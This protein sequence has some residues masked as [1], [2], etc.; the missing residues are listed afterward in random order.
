MSETLLLPQPRAFGRY[1]VRRL[2]NSGG[3]GDVYEAH[4]PLID[5]TVAVKMIRTGSLSGTQQQDYLQR[6]RIEAQAG[7]RC[8]HPSIVAIFDAGEAEGRPYLVMEFVNGTSLRDAADTPEQRE[9]LDP[10][11]IIA[12]V[13][14]ALGH[15]H[16]LGIIHRDIK[17]ANIM[18]TQNGAAKVADFGIARIDQGQFTLSGDILGTPS[19]MA[20]EQANGGTVDHRA[21]LFSTAAVLHMLVSGRP[22][23]AGAN[24]AETL[25]RLTAPD[26]ADLTPLRGSRFA[27]LAPV[28]ARGL[29]KDK[30]ARFASAAEFAAALRSAGKGAGLPAAPAI[31]APVIAAA[32]AELARHLGPIAQLTAAEAARKADGEEAFHA[33]IARAMPDAKAAQAYLSRNTPPAPA[34]PQISGAMIDAATAILRVHIG[35]I[36]R[37]LTAEAARGADNVAAFIEAVANSVPGDAEHIRHKLAAALAEAR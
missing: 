20:P 5:R 7:G 19:Y 25:R 3:V 29:A 37:L 21:D 27:S 31:P 36:A 8:V 15:A 18:L 13:L 10:Q 26:P 35:P 24:M 17:P 6:F 1:L 32:A 22:P 16:G 12:D 33:L 9:A 30:E 2:I 14:A 34:M 23:F 11:A 28:L 4:D